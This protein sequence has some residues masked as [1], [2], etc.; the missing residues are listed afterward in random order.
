LSKFE[1][2]SRGRHQKRNHLPVQ[3]RDQHRSWQRG[4]QQVQ[5]LRTGGDTSRTQSGDY[6]ESVPDEAD[7]SSP[8]DTTARIEIPGCPPLRPDDR[9]GLI[10]GYNQSSVSTPR[11]TPTARTKASSNVSEARRSSDIEP[12]STIFPSLMIATL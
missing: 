2:S 6:P 5:I 11:S 7:D 1:R 9:A 4:A 12:S 8:A 10:H 3:E